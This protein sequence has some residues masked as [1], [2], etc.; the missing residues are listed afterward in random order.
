MS[1]LLFKPATELATLIHTGQISSAEL[2]AAALERIEALQPTINAFTHVDAEGAI[3]AAEAIDADDPRPFAGVPIAI[4]DTDA[5]GGD[6]VHDG[7]GP[8]R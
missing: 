4:K 2:V 1:E 6:A 3:A 5:G 8:L 7:L